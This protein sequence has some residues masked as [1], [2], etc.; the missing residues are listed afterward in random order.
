MAV[1]KK[2]KL[3][4]RVDRVILTAFVGVFLIFISY[5]A[6]SFVGDVFY[7]VFNSAPVDSNGGDKE[8]NVKEYKATVILDPGHGGYDAGTNKNGILEKDI[9]LETAKAAGKI[10]EENNVYV[11]YTRVDDRALSDDKETDLVTRAQYSQNN[12]AD[13]FVSIHV[14]DYEGNKDI[15]GFE[16][17][18]RNDESQNLGECIVKEIDSLNL[19]RNRGL[20]NGRSLRVLNA[21]TVP[22]V[23]V[24]LGYIQGNDY[25]YL[26][27]KNEQKKLGEAI[28]KGILNAI[29]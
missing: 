9:V 2:K 20:Q 4:L 27:N 28:A 24:E 16:V 17:Y 7:H 22:A 6:I 21:N 25:K 19:T 8:N 15:S 12:N 14:N 23:L 3:K 10:L 29:E 1:K 26:S 11:V 13:F 18:V 5:K